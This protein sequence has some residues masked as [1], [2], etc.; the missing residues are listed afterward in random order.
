M[1]KGL[2]KMGEKERRQIRRFRNHVSIIV[3]QTGAVIAAVFVLIITQLFQ[4]ID[5]LM[6]SDLSFV[7]SKGFLILLG[8]GAL[9]VV[10]LLG[11]LLVWSRTYI[12][13]EE[14]AVVIE[15]GRVN[16]K[17]NT[18][19][20]RNIS[21]INLEQNLIEMLFGT[22]KV[23]LDTNSRSTAD[24]T[25]VKIVLKKADALWFQQEV[26]RKMEEAAGMGYGT[27]GGGSETA[28]GVGCMTEGFSFDGE[29]AQSTYSALRELKDYD[30]HSGITDI[31]EHG[32]F[33]ISIISVAVFLLVI[34]GSVISVSEV[35]G[36]ADLMASLAAAASGIL[37]AAFIILSTLWDTVKDFVRYYDFRAKRLGD[38]IYI[39]YGFFKKVEYTIP[40]DKIQALKIRQ[41]FLARIGRQYMAEIV[42]VGLGDDKEEKHSFLVL[43]CT[44]EKLKERL[45]LLLPEFSSS[46][47]QPVDRLPVSVWAAWTVP[48]VI[49]ILL[50]VV[51]AYMGSTLTGNEYRMYIWIMAAVLI[52]MLFVGMILKYRTAGVGV[53]DKYLKIIRGYFAKEFLSVHYRN[54]QY[55]KFSQNFIARACGIKKGAIH[56]LAS[57]ANTSQGIPYFDGDK[58]EIIKRKLLLK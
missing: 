58:E 52:I 6:G 43:Y 11:Q 35:L 46:V 51:G 47:E 5:E 22:C 3:E 27:T 38:K 31:M 53:N 50:V 32:F 16:K 33:S 20:I 29:S 9:L 24:S 30:V 14:N 39:R 1:G 44:K 41:S 8:V 55:V 13:I 17:K 42:N 23:K 19:G 2:K 12:S 26:T 34:V 10:S 57:S 18:I 54:I 48:A 56:L 7:T 36:R 37:V 45:S 21:N 40:V 4:S 28:D 15:K 49:Y 25:D